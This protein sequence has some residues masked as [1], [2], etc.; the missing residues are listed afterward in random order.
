MDPDPRDAN[1]RTSPTGGSRTLRLLL[2]N[3]VGMVAFVAV[4]LWNGDLRLALLAGVLV[5]VL[6]AIGSDVLIE[7]WDL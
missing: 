2:G 3:A 7:A 1:D 6:A 4:L 5:A